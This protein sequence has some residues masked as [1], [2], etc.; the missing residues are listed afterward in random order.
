VTFL[1]P[2]APASGRRLDATAAS[3]QVA[4]LRRV[5]AEA[6]E[7]AGVRNAVVTL[8]EERGMAETARADVALAVSEACTNV[9]MHAY[10]D[11]PSP[12]DLTVEASHPNGEF[13][14]AVRDDGRGMQPRTDSPGMGLGLPL[15]GR[16]AHRV[17][18]DQNGARGTEVRLTFLV[19]EP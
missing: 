11:A 6:D 16:L 4:L 14:V 7:I 18:I 13:V 17:E 3:S 5:P 1:E 12:G 19:T 2:V 10:I 9:V 8:A 15:I